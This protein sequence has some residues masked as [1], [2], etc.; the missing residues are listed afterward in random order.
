MAEYEKTI[1]Q[2]IGE[3]PDHPEGLEGGLESRGSEREV[4]EERPEHPARGST[5]EMPAR[6]RQSLTHAL[7]RP[8]SPHLTQPGTAH[9]VEKELWACKP[10][11]CSWETIG[12]ASPKPR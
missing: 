8:D 4:L 11:F 1:A 9:L 2:M 10:W 12:L 5:L 3:Y 6:R 7:G